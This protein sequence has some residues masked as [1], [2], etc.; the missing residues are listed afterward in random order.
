MS[1]AERP[2][3][4]QSSSAS[5]SLLRLQITPTYHQDIAFV[6]HDPEP[7]D[8]GDDDGD[9]EAEPEVVSL[10]LGAGG[11]S[12]RSDHVV[13]P[14]DYGGGDTYTVVDQPVRARPCVGAMSGLAALPNWPPE[15]SALSEARNRQQSGGRG[16]RQGRRRDDS[17][18]PLSL[19]QAFIAVLSAMSVAILALEC[20]PAL[21]PHGACPAVLGRAKS[22]I[23]GSFS[24][25]RPPPSTPAATPTPT[26]T[27]TLT[28]TPS[29]SPSPS[30][31]APPAPPP[32]R[33]QFL[34][35]D[36]IRETTDLLQESYARLYD[37]WF[38]L[39]IQVEPYLHDVVKKWEDEIDELDFNEIAREDPDLFGPVAGDEL[40]EKKKL[41]L[42]FASVGS[43]LGLI[44]SVGRL[45]YEK[46]RLLE[47]TLEG[48]HKFSRAFNGGSQDPFSWSATAGQPS[49]LEFE[50]ESGPRPGDSLKYHTDGADAV[51][52]HEDGAAKRA[53]L[54]ALFAQRNTAILARFQKAVGCPA[55]V[56]AAAAG[57]PRKT[58]EPSEHDDGDILRKFHSNDMNVQQ[59]IQEM[60]EFLAPTF[61]NWTG[62]L[63]NLTEVGEAKRDHARRWGYMASFWRD[64]DQFGAD[65]AKNHVGREESY[66]PL[67]AVGLPR[68]DLIALRA[69][70]AQGIAEAEAARTVA[71]RV[72]EELGR[73][74][75]T[76]WELKGKGWVDTVAPKNPGR[77]EGN[78][79]G[80]GEGE[81]EG[82][83]EGD[84]VDDLGKDVTE[85]WMTWPSD[86]DA[87]KTLAALKMKGIV[88]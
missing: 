25:G 86:A 80:K 39:F 7:S 9:D 50:F 26:L 37:S 52:V 67:V 24:F 78:G 53:R 62:I 76:L 17:G 85:F 19:L 46:Q 84:G 1:S 66:G 31:T 13:D 51:H 6:F 35:L 41:E 10:H 47:A 28:P 42:L 48:V 77:E 44:T 33:V 18:P 68:E 83:G 65:H 71:R 73:M 21:N 8:D 30:A 45:K 36:T 34:V 81:G 79:K 22:N 57:K 72:H 5:Y 16:Q 12:W 20:V 40:V 43:L 58:K 2:P 54:H 4:P 3:A 63:T 75:E 69:V 74:C 64:W 27:P 55:W 15:S 32:V 14:N 88:Y 38:F 82:E 70:L 11:R 56:M 59:V 87:I 61:G 23:I 49:R 60:T 29:R